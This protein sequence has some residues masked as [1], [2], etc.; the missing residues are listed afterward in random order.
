[1]N[2]GILNEKE[3]I[4]L[5]TNTLKVVFGFV[6][7]LGSESDESINSSNNFPSPIMHHTHKAAEE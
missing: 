1:M 3:E 4:V 2:R 7:L 5:A 6:F